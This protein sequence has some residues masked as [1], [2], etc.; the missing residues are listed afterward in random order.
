MAVGTTADRTTTVTRSE[1]WVLSMI[2][3]FR[4]YSDEIVPKVSPVLI[5]RV[6][7]VAVTRIGAAGE[8]VHEADLRNIFAASSTASSPRFDPTAPSET[9]NPPLMKKNGV[10]KRESHDAQTLLLLAVLRVVLAHH[11]S[12]HERGQHR[13]SV[14][15]VREHH[16]KQVDTRTRA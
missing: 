6:A 2:P 14:R 5:K 9:F 16:E 15:C 11:E 8:R 10:R 1:N 7:N 13:V 3:A 4:P 12:E